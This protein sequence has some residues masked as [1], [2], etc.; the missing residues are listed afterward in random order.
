MSKA[1]YRERARIVRVFRKLGAVVGRTRGSHEQ[2]VLNGAA[3]SLPT[4]QREFHLELAL[5]IARSVERTW[6]IERSSY[7][8]L[9]L[10]A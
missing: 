10:A 2:W 3:I 9:L 6:R 7:E 5:R 4:T 8:R 1:M